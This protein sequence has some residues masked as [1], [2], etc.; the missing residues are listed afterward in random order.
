MRWLAGKTH[1]LGHRKWGERS[2]P[3]ALDLMYNSF[4]DITVDGDK[5]LDEDYVMNIFK[6][7]YEEL[8]ELDSHLTYY[9]KDKEANVICSCKASD[10]V[11]AI[12]GA[13]AKIFYPTRHE[14][15]Q[16]TPTCRTLA[17]RLGTRGIAECVHQKKAIASH[18]SAMNGKKSW[19]VTT[20]E[21]KAASFGLRANND[22]AEENFAVF[23][24]AFENHKRMRLDHAAGEGQTRYN[25]DYGRES[26]D[27]VSGRKSKREDV[28]TSAIGLFHE[29]DV[30]L[31][32]SLVI[33]R[34]KKAPVDRNNF[35]L[36]QN[37][38]ALKKATKRQAIQNK[39]LGITQGAL[40]DAS[41]LYQQYKS[42]RCVLTAKDAFNIFDQLSSNVAK[43]KFFKEQIHMRYLGLGWTEAH[44]PFSKAGHPYT[45]V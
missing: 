11:L 24:N 9:F 1:T 36:A 20:E 35:T 40:I 37:A 25:N 2:I 41:Y 38:Q 45:P 6:P 18:L 44:H 3:R 21:E 5:F 16:T 19:V 8:P 7:L 14:N 12:D 43:Y 29:L 4:I 42:A 33:T 13:V 32:N 31:Q 39:K 27:L 34:K 30:L 23:S 26:T 17:V 15:R 28:S 10:Q 22:P